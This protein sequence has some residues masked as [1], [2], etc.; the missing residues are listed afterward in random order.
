MSEGNITQE[1]TYA[2]QS[3]SSDTLQFQSVKAE[4]DDGVNETARN[5][6][7]KKSLWTDISDMDTEQSSTLISIGGTNAST[8]DVNERLMPSTLGEQ[9]VDDY[10]G[11]SLPPS[12]Q[13]KSFFFCFTI[14]IFQFNY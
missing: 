2:M 1:N 11:P 4:N 5:I 14:L 12:I 9:K 7:E 8:A 10:Y 3:D 13:C 6:R